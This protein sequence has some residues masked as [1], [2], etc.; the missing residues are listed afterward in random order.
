[1]YQIVALAGIAAVVDVIYH[2][3]VHVRYFM[4]KKQR[5]EQ[6]SGNRMDPYDFKPTIYVV[7]DD[8][9]R[10]FGETRQQ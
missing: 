3:T 4:T 7:K 10:T 9:I 5:K 2:F 1:M 6:L 8:P